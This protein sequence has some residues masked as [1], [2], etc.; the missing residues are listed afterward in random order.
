MH[1]HLGE[2]L[3]AGVYLAAALMVVIAIVRTHARKRETRI[4]QMQPPQRPAERKRDA[5]KKK[6]A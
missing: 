3:L 2:L 1:L 5:K 6:A 4:Q